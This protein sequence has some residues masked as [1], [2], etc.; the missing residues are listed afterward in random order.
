[1]PSTTS[2]RSPS[3]RK[4]VHSSPIPASIETTPEPV[5]R[6]KNKISSSHTRSSPKS[7]A[8]LPAVSITSSQARPR[9]RPMLKR[10]VSYGELSAEEVESVVAPSDVDDADLSA[11]SLKRRGR[12]LFVDD[13]ASEASHVS[14]EPSADEDD[15]GS[16]CEAGSEDGAVV[17]SLRSLSK[18]KTVKGSYVD[19]LLRSG[20]VDDV[21]ESDDVKNDP[22]LTAKGNV[23]KRS[24]STVYL[25][26]L[27]P[28][29]PKSRPK[30]KSPVKRG[31][32]P[33]Q[34]TA[35]RSKKEDLSTNARLETQVSVD[36]A[37]STLIKTMGL[38]STRSKGS[39]AAISVH[40]AGDAVADS[41][42]EQAELH[43]H[44][45]PVTP[46]QSKPSP[47]KSVAGVKPTV[48][49]TVGRGSAKVG[50][51]KTSSA[52]A[53]T[54]TSTTSRPRSKATVASK[55]DVE[56][57]FSSDNP[58]D[59]STPAAAPA[60][61]ITSE[62]A[63]LLGDDV[64]GSSPE[65]DDAGPVLRLPEIGVAPYKPGPDLSEPDDPALRVMQPELMEEHLVALGVYVSLPPLG[66][67]RAVVPTGSLVEAFKFE[68]YGSFVNLAARNALCSVFGGEDV[69]SRWLRECQRHPGRCFVVNPRHGPWRSTWSSW[70]RR[71]SPTEIRLHAH[72]PL[73]PWCQVILRRWVSWMKALRLRRRNSP[74]SGFLNKGADPSPVYYGLRDIQR[75]PVL[76]YNVSFRMLLVSGS[77]WVSRLYDRT[78]MLGC[79][80]K[81]S[82]TVLPIWLAG[83]PVFNRARTLSVSVPLYDS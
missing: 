70:K 60:S 81:F 20:N 14:E 65:P 17:P 18:V 10:K 53:S 38:S 55:K 12:V 5:P 26:D 27:E 61:Q 15:Y 23:R 69:A 63:A 79:L 32:G 48:A 4:L 59:D 83:L 72:L 64:R 6:K 3:K 31:S 1:M 74:R 46:I 50:A 19:A 36:S 52:K 68:R 45:N 82:T 71:A 67:Y 73:R 24:P 43:T 80:E 39:R 16:D 62:L 11:N 76:V 57:A 56:P 75:V 49:S 29:A 40:T 28:F 54:R 7:S 77:V 41:S 44:A 42:D 33:G 78:C 13:E 47:S 22:T 66:V 21:A 25:E 51:S 37:S 30:G 2:S 58:D 34:R 8:L 35:G 9:G